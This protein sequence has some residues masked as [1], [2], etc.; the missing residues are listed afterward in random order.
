MTA[1][2]TLQCE[3]VADGE[4]RV[5][6]LTVVPDA[7]ADGRFAEETECGLAGYG[8][9]DD[10]VC[11]LTM[12]TAASWTQLTLQRLPASS[13]GLEAIADVLRQ[14]LSADGGP[15]FAAP[16]ADDWSA[17]TC[18]DLELAFASIGKEA[19]P[20]YPGF[21]GLEAFFPSG[22]PD[23]FAA[24]GAHVSCGWGGDLP[25]Q[26]DIQIGA[27]APASSLDGWSPVDVSGADEA[28]SKDGEATLVAVRDDN[29]LVMSSGTNATAA[30]LVSL[31]EAILL[32]AGS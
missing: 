11:R 3:W 12:R 23:A 9:T 32:V 21:A 15:V 6:T 29:R 10:D 20:G 25:A 7:I 8:G 4:W 30:D 16:D 13:D 24:A 19:T 26:V 28:W 18:E 5:L 17:L 27:G 2:N 14:R 22:L 31:A 1:W